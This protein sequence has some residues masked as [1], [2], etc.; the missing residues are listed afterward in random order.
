[1]DFAGQN[2]LQKVHALN[3]VRLTQNAVAENKPVSAADPQSFELTA[4]AIDFKVAEGH[5]LQQAVTS[6]GAHIT[7]AQA[8]GASP[9]SAHP[10][11]QRT[12]VTAG[13]FQAQFAASEGRNRLTSVHGAPDARIVNSAPGEPDRVSTSDSVDATFLPQ[14]GIDSITQQGNVAYTDGQQPD[15]RMQAWANSARYTPSDQMLLLTGDPR[16]AN[17][18]MATTATTIRINRATGDALAQ[19]DVKSTYSEL[20]EQPDGALLASSSPIHITAHTMTARGKPGVATYSEH[21][22]LWQD[23]NVIEAQAIEFDRN[24][25]SVTA[26]G[27]PAQ[28][29]QTILFQAEKAQAERPQTDK[30]QHGKTA[31]QAGS[32][33]ASS[34]ISVTASKLTYAD[35]ERRVHY[36]DGVVAQGPGFTASATTVDAFLLPRSQT[37]NNRSFAGP[38]QLDRMIAQGNVVIRQP[39]R[40]AEGE[41]LVYTAAADKFV[42]TGGPPSIF[43]AEQGKITGVS[44]TFFRGDDRVLVEGEA[45]TPVVTQTRV[46]Q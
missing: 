31:R 46:A 8:Q 1:V 34:P 2:Q 44:L 11:A 23:A 42:L 28:P 36:E 12:V 41:R 45:N 40:R 19:G 37:S 32:P 6:G 21:A 3:G 4:P 16:V 13:K 27:T 30:A 43:D 17:G 26:Q 14:G 18:G 15:K 25:R 9:G 39:K 7:I 38:G 35:A 33:A 5:I 29:V 10:A 24:R 20:K 22:R